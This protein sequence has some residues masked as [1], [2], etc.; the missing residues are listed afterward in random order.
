MNTDFEI[1]QWNFLWSKNPAENFLDR[2]LD[3]NPF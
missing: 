3:S 1:I 2:Y